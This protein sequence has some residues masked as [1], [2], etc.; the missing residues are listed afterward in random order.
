MVSMA[1]LERGAGGWC[2]GR[3]PRWRRGA[4]RIGWWSG[5]SPR[6]PSTSARRPSIRQA[7]GARRLIGAS[8]QAI[9][10]VG[11]E[12][13]EE[14]ALSLLA[15]SL[16]DATI[17]ATWL[18]PTEV[19]AATSTERWRERLGVAAGEI[20]GWLVLAD[21]FHLDAEGLVAGLA[22]AY[23]GVPIVGGMASGPFRVP[24]THVFLD[25]AVHAEGAV[26][27]GLGGGV[28]IT[29]VVSQGCQPIG[30]VWTITGVAHNT[31]TS[32]GNR[33]ALEVLIETL[34]GLPEGLRARAQR[35]LLVGLA[36][37]EYRTSHGRGD[38]LIRNLVGIDRER[39][40]LAVAAL[41][42]VGQTVQFQMRDAAAADDE[43]Q[44]LLAAARGRLAER[45]PVAALVCACNG[46]GIGLFGTPD[47]D[48]AALVGAFGPL[49]AAGLFCNGEIGPV[50][51]RPFLH[52]FTASLA[53]IGPV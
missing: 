50:G 30:E 23:P 53:L 19:A 51:G 20:N 18:S 17:A 37:D 12:V 27:I 10:G 6:S 48:A 2:R 8:G 22:G 45:A 11:R 26:V 35:N 3:R 25:D 36:M 4:I 34:H 31:I 42:R 32:I 14:P 47:H 52:G 9:I 49:P 16:P 43:L 13:E 44:H 29:P 21:P 15:L 46:R 40:A 5:S 1:M 28:G 39:G 7:T 38:F 24:T 41:P 33:P